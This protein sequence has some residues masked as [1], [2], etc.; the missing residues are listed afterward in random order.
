[1]TKNLAKQLLNAKKLGYHP[2]ACLAKAGL[3]KSKT[4]TEE[5]QMRES[6]RIDCL[7]DGADASGLTIDFLVA[8]TQGLSR[9][10]L[11]KVIGNASSMPAYMKSS[12]N[13]YV[14][15]KARAP[16]KESL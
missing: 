15:R 14:S 4:K 13:P 3:L 11:R 5:E 1:M 16:S 10:A 2:D 8:L 9:H 7:V 12:D 6:E